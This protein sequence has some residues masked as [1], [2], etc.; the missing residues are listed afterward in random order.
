MLERL[1]RLQV[2]EG[3]REEQS[4]RA[5]VLRREVGGA[6]VDRAHVEEGS[7]PARGEGKRRSVTQA[8]VPPPGRG[9]HSAIW[10]ADLGRCA[11]GAIRGGAHPA[12][13]IEYFAFTLVS[14]SSL[15]PSLYLAPSTMAWR[16]ALFLCV[17][18][19][20][21][22]EPLRAHHKQ[23]VAQSDQESEEVGDH[24]QARCAEPGRRAAHMEK[25]TSCSARNMQ[26]RPGTFW[27]GVSECSGCAG[28]GGGIMRGK[29][30][31]S[32]AARRL[33]DS[34]SVG[35]PVAPHRALS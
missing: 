8:A 5:A 30:S 32:G 14:I 21:M 22:V 18:G 31:T 29:V 9:L 4:L 35:Q 7:V 19:M 11:E 12:E 2:A 33:Y 3:E 26:K 15:R 27:Y 20:K 24:D 17:P 1:D 34:I 16:C 25:L 10:G 13:S 28:A 23:E 6:R